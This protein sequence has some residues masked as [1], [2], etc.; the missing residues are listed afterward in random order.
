MLALSPR[1]FADAFFN[2]KDIPLMVA[3]TWAVCSMVFFSSLHPRQIELEN[4][5]IGSLVTSFTMALALSTRILG[6]IP[7]RRILS[8]IYCSMGSNQPRKMVPLD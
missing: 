5:G 6:I 7:G 2:A 1:I 4:S 3:F 8:W